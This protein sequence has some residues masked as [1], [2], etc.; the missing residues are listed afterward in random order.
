MQKG[1]EPYS[2]VQ[3]RSC[4]LGAVGGTEEHKQYLALYRENFIWAL[5]EV[6]F[7]DPALVG[8]DTESAVVREAL[9]RRVSEAEEEILIEAAYFITGKRSLDTTQRLNEKGVKVRVLTNSLA[10]NNVISAHAGYSKYRQ[11]LIENGVEIYEL[12]PDS[13]SVT[14]SWSEVAGRSES[15]L[16]TKA[17]VFDR[18]TAFIGSYNLDPRSA[19]INTELGLMIESA[20]LTLRVAE[21][22][23]EGIRPEN[24]YRVMLNEGGDGLVWVTEEDGEEVRYYKDP[25]STFGQRFKAASS[26]S[27]RWNPSCKRTPESGLVSLEAIWKRSA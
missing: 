16:H 18:K 24:S 25:E 1:L 10:S 14:R 15:N 12:R 27:F 3:L 2:R 8:E 11:G 7:D 6:L 5:G 26:K 4:P 17:I 21:Y 20:E 19:K 22:M 9:Y 13:D 23:D